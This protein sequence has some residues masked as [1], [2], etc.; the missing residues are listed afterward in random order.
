MG[1]MGAARWVLVLPLTA[2]GSGSRP[3]C[4][5]WW[6]AAAVKSVTL[7][8]RARCGG[9]D[10]VGAGG[11][12]ER[13]DAGGGGGTAADHMASKSAAADIILVD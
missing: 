12:P 9:I 8:G 7:T 4:V 6:E 1:A 5:G 2:A 11:G 10:V 3:L 13:A